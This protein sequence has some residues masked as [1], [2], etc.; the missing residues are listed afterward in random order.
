MSGVDDLVA[1]EAMSQSDDEAAVR[2]AVE[3]GMQLEIREPRGILETVD[4]WAERAAEET[5]VDG[6]TAVFTAGADELG[7][8]H[9]PVSGEGSPTGQHI[10]GGDDYDPGD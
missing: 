3:R 5:T 7:L 1:L 8:G 6:L 2:S 9:D 10:E 4:S